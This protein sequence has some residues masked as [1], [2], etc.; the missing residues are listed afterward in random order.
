MKLAL[1]VWYE[2][3][4]KTGSEGAPDPDRHHDE[5][6]RY[7]LWREDYLAWV[8]GKERAFTAVERADIIGWKPE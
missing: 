5:E 2:L 7:H 6:D 8:R 3:W 4:E 1:D